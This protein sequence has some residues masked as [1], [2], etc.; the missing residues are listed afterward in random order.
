MTNSYYQVEFY[1]DLEKRWVPLFAKESS[2]ADAWQK[3][4]SLLPNCERRVVKITQTSEVLSERKRETSAIALRKFSHPQG[5]DSQPER[6]F[7]RG[8][9]GKELRREEHHRAGPVD[10]PDAVDDR[11]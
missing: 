8:D 5:F 9:P 11:A 3:A 6:Q 10:V 4:Y 7:F 2:E 1:S